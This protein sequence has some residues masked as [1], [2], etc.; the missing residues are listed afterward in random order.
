[1]NLKEYIITLYSYEDLEKFYNDMETPGGNLYIPE[2]SV[3]VSNRRIVS[4]NTHYMLTEEEAEI[5]KNDP[6]VKNVELN[7][8]DQ[9]LFF[10][11]LYSQDSN[12]WN[13]S[14]FVNENFKNWGLL[15]CVEGN[16]RTNWGQDGV[17]NQ[18]G[19]IN[20]TS[21]GKN[22]DIVIIDGCIDPNHPEFA[23]NNN[24][25]GGSRVIQFNWFSLR[26]FVVGQSAGNYSYQPYVDPSY[27]D[28][29]LDGKSD[30]TDDND[31]GCH[32]AGIAAGNTNGW[33]RNAN[34]YNLN[35][36]GSA[37]TTIPSSTFLD[38]IRYWHNNKPVNPVTGLRNPTIVNNSYGVVKRFSIS[39]ITE[40]RFNGNLYSAPFSA[41]QL[42]NFGIPNDNGIVEV[43]ILIQGAFDEDIQDTI[44]DGI[45]MIA[46]AGNS[47]S[48]IENV[49]TNPLSAY[50]NNFLTTT[51]EIIYY[52]RGTSPGSNDNV[53]CVGDVGVLVNEYK[54]EYSNCGPRVDVYAP[55]GYI[56]SSVNS[57]LGVTSDDSRDTNYKLT[58]KSGTSMASPQVT[59]IIACFAEQNPRINQEVVKNYVLKYSKYNQLGDTNGGYDDVTSLQGSVNRYIFYYK[60]RNNEGFVSPKLNSGIR[61]AQGVAYPRYRILRYG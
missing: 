14:S 48:K 57:D 3:D 31:H 6:R 23:V 4:R 37:P 21:S 5:I 29:N 32:V 53:I 25:S 12:F 46:S 15:R 20:L 16:Q 9:N 50:N 26:P 54:S 36:Y 1:M 45:I 47:F 18:S 34:I 44:N 28:F 17:N 61:K 59:G 24:G 40:V 58:K 49:S 55:G 8:N 42:Y 22:V 13:K 52:S 51:G 30:R 39:Q 11:P 60:E 56:T 2:R 7:Y 35:P 19:E 38:Y 27:P 43:P 10:K 33:A 41:E